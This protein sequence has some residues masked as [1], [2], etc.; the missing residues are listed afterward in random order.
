M[1]K[2]LVGTGGSLWSEAAVAFAAKLAKDEG[3][4]LIVLHV[5]DTPDKPAYPV[6]ERKQEEARK[7][8]ERSR[9]IAAQFL[10]AVDARSIKGPVASVLIETADMEKC[11]LIVMGSRGRSR[12]KDRLLGS[13]LEHVIAY[14]HR[15][16]TVVKATS[17]V[18]EILKVGEEK[19]VFP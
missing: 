3:A 1:K 6:H 13:I 14:S 11:D 9:K 16:V 8:L 15:P 4:H 19:M 5:L 18:E 10:G 7:V 17:E 12:I 2:I